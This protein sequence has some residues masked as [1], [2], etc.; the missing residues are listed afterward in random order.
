VLVQK[1][2]FHLITQEFNLW[3]DLIKKF[4]QIDR[5]RRAGSHIVIA[6]ISH[7]V[8]PQQQLRSHD[9]IE[10]V[11]EGYLIFEITAHSIGGLTQQRHKHAVDI[12][13]PK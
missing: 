8:V 9:F 2:V 10:V 3:H 1:V 5:D 7:V 6:Y 11:I 4:K 13:Q 12:H